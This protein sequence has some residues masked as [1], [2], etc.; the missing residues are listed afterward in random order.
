[1]DHKKNLMDRFPGQV[2]EFKTPGLGKGTSPW[3]STYVYVDGK[4]V[5]WAL[6]MGSI[7]EPQGDRENQA[8]LSFLE[9]LDALKVKEDELQIQKDKDSY[10]LEL[11][12]RVQKLQS[13]LSY[14]QSQN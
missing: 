8:A 4:T 14:A 10:I 9:K 11:E 2:V 5:H 6:T 3:R 13:K 7:N 12:H 1:M